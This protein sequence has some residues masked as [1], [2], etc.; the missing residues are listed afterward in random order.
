MEVMH[1]YTLLLVE[2]SLTILCSLTPLLHKLHYC[3]TL[4][5]LLSLTHPPSLYKA[6][7]FH[8]LFC[9]TMVYCTYKCFCSRI[10]N[11]T[12][13]S[14]HTQIPY[15]CENLLMP[16]SLSRR[17]LATQTAAAHESFRLQT[18]SGVPRYSFIRGPQV[19]GIPSHTITRLQLLT[20]PFTRY[21]K[22]REQ[23]DQL[24]QNALKGYIFVESLTFTLRF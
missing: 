14:D 6:P 13:N 23:T 9:I 16:R 11:P 21:A 10:L 1:R 20:K 8:S 15:T 4:L 5:P 24:V 7:F 19:G 2:I 22:Y 3:C 12:T 18:P 17:F